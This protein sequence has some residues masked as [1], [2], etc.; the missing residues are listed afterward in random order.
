MLVD[1]LVQHEVDGRVDRLVEGVEELESKRAELMDELVIKVAKPNKFD[2]KGGAVAYIWWVEKMEVVQ[3]ING[4]GDNQKV[5]YSAG[6]LTGRVLTWWNSERLETEFWNHFMVGVGHLAYTDRF[7]ELARLVPHLVT[8]ET[9]N[10][11][12]YIYGLAPHIREMV[13]A[14][15]PPTIQ[16]AMLNVRVL[17]DEAVRNGSLKRT[18]ER[19]RY[20][21]ESSKE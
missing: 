3:D 15:K 20:G 6:S 1:A 4:Y 9:K 10:I 17:I 18:G 8:P 21:G 13:A 19:T 5:K 16:N 11:K 2:G 7:Y 12:R 14:T